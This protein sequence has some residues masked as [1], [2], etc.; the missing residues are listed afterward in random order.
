MSPKITI[1]ALLLGLVPLAGL[2]DDSYSYGSDAAVQKK[3]DIRSQGLKRESSDI[4]LF[5]E[6]RGAKRPKR[7]RTYNDHVR[8]AGGKGG[9][10]PSPDD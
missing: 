9:L 8:N 1:A 2:A 6:E 3:T 5:D 10:N 4:T 7:P